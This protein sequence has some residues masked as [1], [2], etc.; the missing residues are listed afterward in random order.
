MDDIAKIGSK[1]GGPSLTAYGRTRV[2]ISDIMEPDERSKCLIFINGEE[3]TE[4]AKTTYYV[5]SQLVSMLKQSITVHIHHDFD[6]P[7]GCGYG[8]SGCGALGVAFGLN[9]LLNIGL[10]YNET[11]KIAHIAEVMNK[12]GLGTVGGQLT[13]GLSIT[14]TAGFPFELD[15]ILTPPDLKIVCGSFGPIPTESII[16]DPEHKERIKNAGAWAMNKLMSFPT[17]QRF[18]EISR[19]FVNR[20]GLLDGETMKN[21][22]DLINDLNN[23]DSG[24]LGASMNQLGRSVYCFCEDSVEGDVL[25]IFKSYSS[26]I[27]LKSLE[28][29]NTGPLFANR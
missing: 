4:Q 19:E 18:I 10:S 12:T 17:H 26:L 2:K 22:R 29:C 8:A 3:T 20:I 11:G 13:G 1:G 27:S 5:F 16:G 15:R 6:L 7:V 25:S 24:I 14:T 9:F 28:I 23:G 21:T